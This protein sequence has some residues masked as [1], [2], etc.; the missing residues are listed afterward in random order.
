MY[1][2]QKQTKGVD[3]NFAEQTQKSDDYDISEKTQENK[4]EFSKNTDMDFSGSKAE[5][6]SNIPF[7]SVRDAKPKRIKNL[8]L[9]SGKSCLLINRIKPITQN[10]TLKRPVKKLTPLNPTAAIFLLTE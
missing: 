10:Q 9:K 3:Y 5:R 2:M 8:T 7:D 1:R 6:D 4:T